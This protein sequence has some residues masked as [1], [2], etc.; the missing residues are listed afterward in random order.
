MAFFS[1]SASKGTSHQQAAKTVTDWYENAANNLRT[2][3]CT[4]VDR[5]L[6]MVRQPGM[7]EVGRVFGEFATRVFP[8]F[9][10]PGGLGYEKSVLALFEHDTQFRR[11]MTA[12]MGQT[13]LDE[14]KRARA[15]VA[16]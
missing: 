9:I 14:V 12:L 1:R 6:R 2:V 10:V 15:K 4:S 5:M 3:L 7:K 13:L 8:S 16:T 11:D